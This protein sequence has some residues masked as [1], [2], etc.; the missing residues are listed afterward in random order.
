MKKQCPKCGAELQVVDVHLGFGNPSLY[1]C[2]NGHKVEG[3]ERLY[4]GPG[5]KTWTQQPL[6][7]VQKWSRWD[8]ELTAEYC[9]EH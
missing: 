5:L 8:E 3:N 6:R 9:K 2:T 4:T 7:V 1:L